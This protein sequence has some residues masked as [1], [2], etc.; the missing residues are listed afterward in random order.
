MK[1]QNFLI[2]LLKVLIDNNW[3]DNYGLNGIYNVNNAN[4]DFTTS[5]DGK[6]R[7]IFRVNPVNLLYDDKYEVSTSTTATTNPTT[8]STSTTVTN[9]PTSPS[10]STL[11]SDSTPG[12]NPST[13]TTPAATTT[14]TTS[15]VTSTNDGKNPVKPCTSNTCPTCT[16]S[17]SSKVM[18]ATGNRQELINHLIF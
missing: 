5:V 9:N 11:S 15:K 16:N 7:L 3:K 18:R 17:F 14:A 6:V 4:A 10:A 13:L 12:T 8:S 1:S 2:Y